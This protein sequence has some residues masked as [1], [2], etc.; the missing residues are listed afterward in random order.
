M[1]LMD[2]LLNVP[3]D[4]STG[5]L[6]VTQQDGKGPSDQKAPQPTKT[7]FP[8]QQPSSDQRKAKQ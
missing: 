3:K 1:L 7:D 4:G 6:G 5:R 2:D 8:T